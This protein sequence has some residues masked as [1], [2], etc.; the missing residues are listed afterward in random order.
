MLLACTF[1]G[2]HTWSQHSDCIIMRIINLT[3][4]H[5]LLSKSWPLSPQ[6]EYQILTHGHFLGKNEVY[7]AR[8]HR[9]GYS[10]ISFRI[11]HHVPSLNPT[12]FFTGWDRIV[13]KAR[14]ICVWIS[15]LSLIW[16]NDLNFSR[17]SSSVVNREWNP[18][19]G[20]EY[21]HVP[22]MPVAM[23]RN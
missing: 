14:R 19:G 2:K 3:D 4:E 12:L 22:K 15:A 13:E 1:L 11:Y 18:F 7:S 17:F 21:Y 10:S 5:L 6:A 8:L 16:A 23:T 9:T 20:C